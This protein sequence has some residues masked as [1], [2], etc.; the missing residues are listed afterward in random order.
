MNRRRQLF[1]AI[2]LGSLLAGATAA[3]PREVFAVTAKPTRCLM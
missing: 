2:G 1:G 3:V